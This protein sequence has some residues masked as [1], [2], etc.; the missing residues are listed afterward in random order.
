M[1]IHRRALA[2]VFSSRRFHGLGSR[3]QQ[4]RSRR[5]K[6]RELQ[7]ETLEPRTMLS[8]NAPP[9]NTVPSDIQDAIVNQPFAFTAYRGNQISITD[10]DAAGN[11]EVTLAV[12]QGFLTLINPDPN[13]ALTYSEGNGTED[14]TMIFQGT[15]ESLNTAL[16]WVAFVGD[17]TGPATLTITTDDSPHMNAEGESD[18][19]TIQISVGAVP[20]FAPTP[21]HATNP[22]VLDP[23]IAGT[24]YRIRSVTNQVD[25]ILD[26]KEMPDGTFVAVGAINNTFSIF[27]FDADLNL[28][29]N[30]GK[31]VGEIPPGTHARRFEIDSEGRI[32]VVG[33]DKIVRFTASGQLDESFGNEGIVTWALGGNF[34]NLL[35]DIHILPNGNFAVVGRKINKNYSEYRGGNLHVKEYDSSGVAV[36]NVD[37]S[38]ATYF[39]TADGSKDLRTQPSWIPSIIDIRDDGDFLLAS[40][41]DSFDVVRTNRTLG[42]EQRYD[43][44]LPGIEDHRSSLALP[45]GK[46]LLIGKTDNDVV[47]TRHLPTGAL[48]LTFGTGG[49]TKVPVLNAA[50]EGYRAT[51]A[52]DGKILITGHAHNGSNYDIFVIRLHHDGMLDETFDTDGI[53]SVNIGG[54]ERG[55]AIVVTAD[56]K[57]VIAGRSGN[58]IALVRLL[59]DSDQS[60]LPP[61]QAPINSV[62]G[63]QTVT[64][65]QSHAFTEYRGNLI[66]ISD[67]DAGNNHVQV[68]LEVTNGTVTFANNR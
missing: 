46:F 40:H 53:M 17:S 25:R 5:K 19:D 57:I 10:T 39:T 41:G 14:A 29:S 30:F 43:V 60:S 4:H 52:K 18:T 22:S 11:L 27:R 24:G 51:L 58:N 32:L 16:T 67:A 28:D 66:S 23:M 37:R 2:R 3:L 48:D 36:R 1:S 45:D 13:G 44:P 6:R 50:D 68:T 59:G 49:S 38:T 42:Q 33:G 7:L 8:A 62:P 21:T 26:M 20:A 55:H 63:A 61:N 47:V 15:V 56:N 34:S 12:N 65:D 35:T 64:I 9:E 54:D 31:Q